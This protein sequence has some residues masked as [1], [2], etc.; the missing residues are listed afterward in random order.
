MKL[1][2]IA[3]E[4]EGNNK[5]GIMHCV[6]SYPTNYE[7]ANLLMIKNLKEL[8]PKYDIGFS[9]HTK[10]D[11]SMLVLTCSYLYGANIIEKHFTLDKTLKGNDHYHAMDPD[12]IRKF[13]TNISL[14]NQIN[15]QFKKEPLKCEEEARKQARRSIVATKD[16]PI[17]EII[18]EDMLTFKRPGT[19]IS[20]SK[21][22]SILGKKSKINIK[23]DE[24][25][26][27]EM[28]G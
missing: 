3:D 15:G 22:N 27:Y 19:G 11:E 12:D 26:K 21:L 5:I 7:D 25:I 9:D 18:T 20:P 2:E 13:K 10:P 14:I 23:E 1:L 4:N 17:G 8:F 28:I 24:L 16:I 6:L